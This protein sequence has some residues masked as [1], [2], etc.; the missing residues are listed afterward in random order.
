MTAT[1]VDVP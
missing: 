1:Y